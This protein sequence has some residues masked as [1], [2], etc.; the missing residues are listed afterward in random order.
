MLSFIFERMWKAVKSDSSFQML[1]APHFS[2]DFS[3]SAFASRDCKVTGLI[4]KDSHHLVN[5]FM[6]SLT[7]SESLMSSKKKF[8]VNRGK[9]V[10]TVTRG[11]YQMSDLQM[12]VVVFALSAATRPFCGQR[13]LSIRP[14][15]VVN[16]GNSLT[17]LEFR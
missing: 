4:L 17:S 7:G 6:W 13:H 16:G 11:R 1:H 14:K 2:A 9:Q 10:D 3:P 12:A 8:V 5:V 15:C